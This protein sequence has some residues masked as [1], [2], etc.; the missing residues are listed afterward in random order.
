MVTQ[1]PNRT[2]V[3]AAIGF[4]LSCIGLIVFVWTQFAG[5]VPFAPQGYRVH[6][7][8]AETG[9]LVS[10]ADV[11]ISG[12]NVGRVASVV[13]RG[14]DSEVTLNIQ[15]QYA[16]IPQSTQAIL[17]QKTLLGEAYVQLTPG[18]RTGPKIADGGSI[19]SSQIA[20]TQQLDQV[21]GSFGKPTQQDLQAFLTGSDLSLAGR[22][23]D[24]SN[25]IGSLD[26][27]TAELEAVFSTLDGQRTDLASL[28]RG[29]ATVLSTLGQ[30]SQDLRT[31]ITAGDQ[32]LSATAARN[33][34][35]AATVNVLPPFLAQLRA[36]LTQVN[37]SLALAKPS[38][39]ALLPAA[40]LLRPALADV[41][42]LSGPTVALLHQAPRLLHDATI[43][44]PAITRFNRAF[45]PTLDALVPT[46][47][48]VSP[49]ISFV[50]LYQRELVTAMSNLAA[51]LEASA[52]AQTS[53]GSAAY[54]RS[55]AAVGNETPFG[56]SIRE[57]SNRSNA[58]YS[59][60]ELT[61]LGSGGLLS[62]NCNNASNQSQAGFGFTNVPCRVQPGF[63]WN[64][65]TK[66][67]PHVTAGSRR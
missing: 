59:P 1:A 20:R 6:A 36:S 45:H 58:Y 27:A 46:L 3:L 63:R 25:A 13:N 4:A 28:L 37:T 7:R 53:S 60:G 30:R 24:L 22:S 10:G 50:G 48:Q 21:L 2:S 32:V 9:L 56:Q 49:M 14:V 8:F 35:L 33:T 31:L 65:L 23:E 34:A 55:L 5:P 67:F 51:S 41:I 26:P 40:P 47:R 15:Q 61:H 52:P 12:I 19:P 11:R 16:P 62:A 66:Y 18:D 42:T 38:L 43:A 39:D 44:L 57:P 64:G 54:L 29:S 17:R